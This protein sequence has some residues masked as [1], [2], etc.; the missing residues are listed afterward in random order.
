MTEEPI[1][2][3]NMGIARGKPNSVH[4]NHDCPFCR[5]DQLTGIKEIEGSIILLENKYPVIQDAYPLLII[6]TDQCDSDLSEYSEEHLNKLMAFAMKHWLEMEKQPEYKSVIFYKNHGPLSGGTIRHP[7]MQIIGLKNADYRE[8]LKED[9]FEGLPIAEASGV[10]LNLSTKP[11][12][13]FTEFNV[14]M[15]DLAN[16]HQFAAY[17]QQVVIYLLKH[18]NARLTSYNLFFYHWNNK[19]IAKIVPRFPTSPLFVGFRLRQVSNNL[20]NIVEDFQSVF[21]RNL[22]ES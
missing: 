3:F 2:K 13:G 15:K 16:I 18:F 8:T 14:V 10:T 11:M 5:T 20:E 17:T 6:E 7:H 12:I 4:L 19:Y 9:Y 22:S 21:A 1:L